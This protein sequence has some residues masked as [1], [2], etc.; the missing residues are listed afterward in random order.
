[1]IVTRRSVLP[2]GA[3]ATAAT[4]GST[5]MGSTTMGSTTMGSPPQQTP[6]RALEG[7]RFC[8]VDRASTSG[9]FVPSTMLRDAGIHV[10]DP[11]RF[12]G[13]HYNV[14]RDI[15]DGRCD[16]GAVS[17]MQLADA[18]RQAIDVDE[19]VIAAVSE[20]L[21]PMAVVAHPSVPASMR[22][23]LRNAVLSP[24]A[25]AMVGREMGLSEELATFRAVDDDAYDIIRRIRGE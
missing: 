2:E 6:P 17:S 16:A 1:M 19:L 15:L 10:A 7:V 25:D 3:E 4:M 18:P 24:E 8:F 21:P 20:P 23:R 14:L 11:P 13:D 22:R 5:T 12:S 9:Y